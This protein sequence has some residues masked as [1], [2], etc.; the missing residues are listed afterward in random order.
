MYLFHITILNSVLLFNVSFL[1]QKTFKIYAFSN[2]LDSKESEEDVA[3]V[4]NGT[5]TRD[6]QY[7]NL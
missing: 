1:L 4:S 7:K 5:S 3:S 6:R 2:F